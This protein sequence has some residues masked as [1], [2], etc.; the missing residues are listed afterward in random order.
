VGESYVDWH[1]DSA[2]DVGLFFLCSVDAVRV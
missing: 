2:G 1:L